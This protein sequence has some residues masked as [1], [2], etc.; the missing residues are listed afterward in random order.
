MTAYL[1]LAIH[2]V[3]GQR[4]SAG[5]ASPSPGQGGIVTATAT[6]GLLLVERNWNDNSGGMVRQTPGEGR[7]HGP[8]R[9]FRLAT[10][11]PSLR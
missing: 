4:P 1:V 2:T 7:C 3:A 6:N 9:D 11:G 8:C 10:S 5:T